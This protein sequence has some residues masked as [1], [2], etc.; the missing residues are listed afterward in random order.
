MTE[1][2][3]QTPNDDNGMQTNVWGPAGWLFMHS[4]AQ[5]YPWNPSDDKKQSYL[6]FFK[7]VGE[8]LPCGKCRDSYTKYINTP[9][10]TMLDSDKLKDRATCAKWLYDVHQEVSRGLKKKCNPTFKSIWN[11]YEQYRSKCNIQK[12]RNKKKGCINPMYGSYKRKCKITV[13]KLHF[14][15]SSKIK[16]VSIKKSDNKLK[17]YK[18]T[19][20]INN[21]TKT[22]YFGAAGMSDYTK[23]KDKQRRS[24]YIR[25]H[26]KD[27]RTG[28][29]YRAGYLSMYIL[30][31]KV[32]FNASVADYR[33]RLNI[34]NRTGKFPRKN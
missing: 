21:R 24:N 6:T 18:A 31:N 20:K 17:K 28:K 25:R 7:S 34:Y 14:G 10:P 27:L 9:G 1:F 29:P 4:I 11:R 32:S 19:F 22:I 13:M 16:L 3:K 2:I 8:V 15:K 12:Q 30:W 33:R 26:L 23:H 5:N